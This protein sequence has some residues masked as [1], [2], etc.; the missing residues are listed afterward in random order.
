[1]VMKYILLVEDEEEL[2][3]LL[4]IA[5]KDSGY[6]VLTTPR[7]PQALM[8][9]MNQKF[10]CIV[11]DIKLAQGTG[12]LIVD[13]IRKPKHLNEKTPVI[14]TSGYLDQDLVRNIAGKI[15]GVVVKPFDTENLLQRIAVLCGK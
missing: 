9:C 15:H 3:E 12:D 2:V 7:A 11:L 8:M 1:M 10:D 14:I 4:S 13:G 5:L 6:R